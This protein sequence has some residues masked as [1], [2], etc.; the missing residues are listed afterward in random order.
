MINS[1]LFEG[2]LVSIKC[3][4]AKGVMEF[5]LEQPKKRI[6]ATI[7]CYKQELFEVIKQS[8]G[9][10]V[11]VKGDFQE[12]Y[13]PD[14]KDWKINYLIRCKEICKNETKGDKDNE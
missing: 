7:R 10:K 4:N 8:L 6:R 2:Y 3:K 9:E 13:T 12:V 11:V 1:L 14:N 5:V